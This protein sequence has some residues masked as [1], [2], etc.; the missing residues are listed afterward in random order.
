MDFPN[1]TYNAETYGHFILLINFPNIEV[2]KQE[3]ESDTCISLCFNFDHQNLIF[4]DVSKAR[5]CCK[6]NWRSAS[7]QRLLAR[8]L[9]I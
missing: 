2:R 7:R 5:T 9:M 6:K 4:P 3:T 1:E 8:L